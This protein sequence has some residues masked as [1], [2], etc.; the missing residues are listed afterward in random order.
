MTD[1]RNDNSS[2]FG[3]NLADTFGGSDG[4]FGTS[5]SLENDSYE[6]SGSGG[7]G[8]LF[9]S[10]T[11]PPATFDLGLEFD[12]DFGSDFDT[13]FGSNN[14]DLWN[15]DSDSSYDDPFGSDWSL[16]PWAYDF[17]TPSDLKEPRELDLGW[18]YDLGFDF[19]FGSTEERQLGLGLDN[20][21]WNW[22]A[23]G[24]DTEPAEFSLWGGLPRQ[25]DAWLDTN[26]DLGF[27]FDV[28][29]DFTSDLDAGRDFSLDDLA[30]FHGTANAKAANEPPAV[31][32]PHRS[33]SPPRAD[34]LSQVAQVLGVSVADLESATNRPRQV[35]D[36]QATTGKGVGTGQAA[37]WVFEIG[38]SEEGRVA[39]AAVT[40]GEHLATLAELEAAHAAFERAKAAFETRDQGGASYGLV[41]YATALQAA[42]RRL[43]RAAGVLQ[44]GNT[45]FIALARWQQA[46]P[47]AGI[48]AMAAYLEKRDGLPMHRAV[49]I[50]TQVLGPEKPT[51]AN[52]VFHASFKGMARTADLL[53][54][55]VQISTSVIPLTAGGSFFDDVLRLKVP[56]GVTP[57]DF[58][59]MSRMLR[60][61]AKA[62]GLGDDL[63]IQ[64]SRIDRGKSVR[65]FP[66]LDGK[67][68][69]LDFAVRVDRATFNRIAEDLLARRNPGSSAERTILYSLESG[70]IN[71]K[72]AGLRQVRNEVRDL[73]GFEIDFSI[74]LE[75]GPFDHG[76]RL[77]LP[78]GGQF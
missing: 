53:E 2:G 74:V 45:H 43:T 54:Q 48:P 50:A 18:D 11:Q 49:E 36:D 59:T 21:D 40:P 77:Q 1:I 73:Y 5:T 78:S 66:D 7:F 29:H 67:P 42:Q 44:A 71:A 28:E 68:S 70:K 65:E 38:I 9:D 14:D 26:F 47:G 24:F 3:L 41:S 55:S 34:D 23:P 37:A 6:P 57:D 15:F 69:D 13:D 58:V 72:Q 30:W 35:T 20:L 32:G 52:D 19:D 63:I 60:A 76:V 64:G 51:S 17:G 62:L 75:G 27:N 46:H 10:N 22:N 25:E 56:R 39:R 16:D 31:P 12:T 8:S 61:E 4:G 33:E